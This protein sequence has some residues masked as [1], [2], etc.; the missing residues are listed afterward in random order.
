MSTELFQLRKNNFQPNSLTL[1]RQ[2]WGLN[3]RKIL[4]VVLN[5]LDHVG[6]YEGQSTHS[7]KIPIIDVVK[8][9][10]YKY[11]KECL[12][13]L[14]QKK[15]QYHSEVKNQLLSIVLFP[16]IR[17][18]INN[19]GML[20]L[21]VTR[22]SLDFLLNLGQE[23]TKYN[24]DIF[25]QF[26]SVYSQRMYEIVMMELR[27]SNR[28]T[29]VIEVAELQK[30]FNTN[31]AYADFKKRVL[32][33]A[34]AD[35]YEKAD[36]VINYEPHQKKGKSVISLAFAI[37]TVRDV[38]YNSVEEELD[39]FRSANPNMV[40]LVAQGILETEY[41]FNQEQMKMILSN[42]DLLEK[43]AEV[44]SKIDNGII[45]IKSSK[46]QYMAKSLGFNKTYK[47]TNK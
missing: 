23:Y 28:K 6:K 27:N 12:E 1:S 33:K 47:S 7:F 44:N 39:G 29:F 45:Q 3:E 19:N 43:F 14:Q 41:T 11:I 30:I 31:Y 22:S 26:Q 13:N 34:R 4:S 36:I 2:E 21:L 20:E 9:V 37:T 25:L 10:Q 42:E 15:V 38:K 46:T 5:Q 32:E 35:I 16:D 17:Y 8:H 24:I 18:N 40:R